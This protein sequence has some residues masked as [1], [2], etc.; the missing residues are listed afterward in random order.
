MKKHNGDREKTKTYLSDLS[1]ELINI[2]LSLSGLY[3]NSDGECEGYE[4]FMKDK[5]KPIS[6]LKK[7]IDTLRNEIIDWV[8]G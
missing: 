7:S 1:L 5:E 8:E 4:R 6:K 2:K 3:S